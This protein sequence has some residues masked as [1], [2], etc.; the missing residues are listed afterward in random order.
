[1]KRALVLGAGGFIGSH[2]VK[3]LKA[4][5]FWVRGVD[6]KRPRYSPSPADDFIVGDLRNL[7][8]CEAAFAGGFDEVYQLAA[9][10]GG[11]G[12]VFSGENDADI[13]HNSA[14]INLNV[15]ETAR[16]LP[17]G[18]IFYSSSACMYP[19]YNQLDPLNPKCNEDSAYPAAPDSEYGWE[20]L[21]SERLFFAY[22]RNHGITVRVARYHN[23]FGPE[24]SWN[25]GREKAPAALCRKVAAAANGG[26]IEIWGDGTQTRSFLYVDECLEG[27]L[28]LTRSDFQGPVNIGSEEM[29]SI[30]QFAEMI[31]K[32]AGKR[33]T[34]RHIKGPLGV[35]GRNSDN[36]RIREK[37]NWAPSLPLVDGLTKTYRWIEAKVRGGGKD[38]ETQVA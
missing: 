16:R 21:F 14:Q 8:V 31:A 20:K 5:Q 6:L 35:K 15:L 30:N 17:V 13:M 12:F 37:L 32:I 24:G 11:A 34:V 4:E 28:R 33:V 26:E 27:T 3:R 23:I 9:D 25:D 7:Q 18:R 10:M 22:A 38:L 2:L 1:V 29:V 36:H 19:E